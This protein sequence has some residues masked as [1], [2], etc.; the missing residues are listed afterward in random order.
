MATTDYRQVAF[1]S[2]DYEETRELRRRVLL[3]PF[4]IPLHV[5]STDDERAFHFAAFADG[6]PKA[7]CIGCLLL[8]PRAPGELQLRQMA[9]VPEHRRRGLGTHLHEFAERWA[10]S[11]GAQR[12]FAHAR[13]PAL[14]FYTS[15]G[16]RPVGEPFFEVG[17]PHRGIEKW[18]GGP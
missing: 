13:L 17:L 15:L 10:R 8:V 18:L 7:P 3:E 11:A 1:A 14:P 16:Y 9:V 5:A 4:G 12:L 2:R 6:S